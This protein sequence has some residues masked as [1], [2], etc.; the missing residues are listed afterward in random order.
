[1]FIGSK[2][3]QKTNKFNDTSFISLTTFALHNYSYSQVTFFT[4]FLLDHFVKQVN[5]TTILYTF[6]HFNFYGE[7]II[8]TSRKVSAIIL[9][10]KNVLCF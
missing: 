7:D 4:I 8:I 6:N 9:F 2:Q 3:K 5:M 1:M 10:I